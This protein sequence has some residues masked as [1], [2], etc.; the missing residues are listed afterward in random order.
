MGF[1]NA[2]IAGLCRGTPWRFPVLQDERAR[3][4]AMIR[5]SFFM[6]SF[7]LGPKVGASSG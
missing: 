1:Q 2:L 7:R 6:V 4:R 3:I 5:N